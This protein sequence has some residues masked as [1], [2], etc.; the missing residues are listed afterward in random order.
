MGDRQE[1]ASSSLN[2]PNVKNHSFIHLTNLHW[3]PT[4]HQKPY[5]AL[6]IH[7]ENTCSTASLSS[8]R[9]KN[10]FFREITI[11]YQSIMI[12]LKKGCITKLRRIK[13]GFTDGVILKRIDGQVGVGP[14]RMHIP[15]RMAHPG[16][17]GTSVHRV[18]R[19]DKAGHRMPRVQC[20][21]MR[22]KR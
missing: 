8:L 20:Q 17:G 18:C 7:N 22:S 9:E 3:T 21:E 13:K 11:L 19:E 4:L 12:L 6:E 5:E 15:G 14:G 1:R 16:Q 10:T 2:D